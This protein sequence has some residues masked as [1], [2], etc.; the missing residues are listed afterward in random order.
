M[1]SL[2]EGA[3][4]PYCGECQCS[5]GMPGKLFRQH[6]GFSMRQIKECCGFK[7]FAIWTACYHSS[8][9]GALGSSEIPV[10]KSTCS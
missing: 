5:G 2:E 10:C 4:N 8:V 3:L 9:S 1:C 7:S 6:N